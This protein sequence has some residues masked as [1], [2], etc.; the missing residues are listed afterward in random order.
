MLFDHRT[1]VVKPGRL[2]KQLALYHQHGWQAQR[3]NLGEPYAFL[4]TETGAL[5]SYVHIWVYKDAADR[6]ERRSK[7]M[8]DARWQ[9]YLE[10]SGQAENLLSQQNQ[11][12]NEAP[13]YE[14]RK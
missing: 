10:V 11:L 4:V 5:N 1:Y 6:A 12:M 14:V 8:A 3:E 9:K 13:F 2:Q 7:L